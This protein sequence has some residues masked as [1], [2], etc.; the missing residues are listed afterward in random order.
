[1]DEYCSRCPCHTC[2]AQ[3][4][5]ERDHAALERI[6]DGLP[7]GIEL[8]WSGRRAGQNID[9]DMRDT[10]ESAGAWRDTWRPM[11]GNRNTGQVLKMINA[12]TGR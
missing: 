9:C 3:R 4:L 10:R 12:M 1:M 5:T 7:A 6:R 11:I 2:R 8:R